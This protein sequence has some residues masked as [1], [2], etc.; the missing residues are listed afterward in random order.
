MMAGS[1][2]CK[3][4]TKIYFNGRRISE[5][6]CEDKGKTTAPKPEDRK[7]P[8]RACVVLSKGCK[9]VGPSY[10]RVIG[11]AAKVM[12]N[13]ENSGNH[14]WVNR[15]SKTEQHYPSRVS[16]NNNMDQQVDQV[17]RVSWVGR[18]TQVSPSSSTDQQI[19]QASWVDRV[20]RVSCMEQ[21]IG[22]SSRVTNTEVRVMEN[23]ANTESWVTENSAK[24]ESR[25]KENLAKMESRGT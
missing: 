16:Q 24:T 20:S 9:V 19:D 3:V 13:K 2:P 1:W 10:S 11:V 23:S 8:K 4:S 22:G 15:V 25:A 14:G 17:G 18:V 7:D 5:P 12:D 6:V 21:K